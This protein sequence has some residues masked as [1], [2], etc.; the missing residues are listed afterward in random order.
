MPWIG[1]IKEILLIIQN[2]YDIFNE[3]KLILVNDLIFKLKQK[4]SIESNLY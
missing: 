1:T 4:D 3:M 2:Q